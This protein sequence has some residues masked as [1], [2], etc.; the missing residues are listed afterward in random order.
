MSEARY[1][2]H[3][4][5][6]DHALG[7]RTEIC[8]LVCFCKR[9]HALKHAT[10]WTVRQLPGGTLEWTGPSGAQFLDHPPPRV[11]FVPS[12]DPPPF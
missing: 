2:D 7:G 11:V 1:C 6:V 5:T 12:E 10:D 8:N 9:H 4:H 3:D